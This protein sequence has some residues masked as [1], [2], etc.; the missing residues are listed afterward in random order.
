[1]KDIKSF[2]KSTWELPQNIVGSIVKKVSKA[3]F[4]TTYKDANVYTWKMMAGLSLGKYIFTPFEEKHMNRMSVQNHIK[5]EY[6]HCIQSKTLGWLYLFVIAIPSIIWA[7]CFNWYRE[8]TGTSY[9][10]FYTE[11]S[12][13]KLGGVNRSVKESENKK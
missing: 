8:K 12:A 5:H 3:K 10:D 4:C 2:M 13:D 7:G 11:S 9:Y 1:M 6:G